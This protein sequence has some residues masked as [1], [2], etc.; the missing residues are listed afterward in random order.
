EGDVFDGR[1]MAERH[2]CLGGHLLGVRAEHESEHIV[3]DGVKPPGEHESYLDGWLCR[4]KK[5]GGIS[6]GR[7]VSTLKGLG[8]SDARKRRGYA[9]ARMGR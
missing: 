6:L 1:I 7:L 9:S 3:G 8:C 2:V 5:V 4:E